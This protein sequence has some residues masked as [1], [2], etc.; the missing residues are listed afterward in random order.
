M[1]SFMRIFLLVTSTF[2]CMTYGLAQDSA[3]VEQRAENLRAQLREVLD[4]ESAL[5]AR[6]QQLDYE[7]QPESIQRRMALIGTTRPEEVREQIRRELESEK[8]K[9]RAQLDQL[10]T[11]RTRLEAAIAAAEAEADRLRMRV[12][13][14]PQPP[15]NTAVSVKETPKQRPLRRQRQ[16]R[17]GKRSRARQR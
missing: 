8:E 3:S 13:V 14:S 7:L 11:S 17:S 5:Q 16:R 10:A 6:V 15:S 12:D 2:I 9:V 1:K 4:K